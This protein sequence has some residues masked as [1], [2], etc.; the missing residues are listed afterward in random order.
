MKGGE[1]QVDE[2]ITSV[3]ESW[4]FGH[5]QRYEYVASTYDR[6]GKKVEKN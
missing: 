2:V 6:R 1:I 3:L 4:Q 5:H